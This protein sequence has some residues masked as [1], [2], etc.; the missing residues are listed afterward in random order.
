MTMV[1][2]I[3]FLFFFRALLFPFISL[4]EREIQMNRRVHKNNS[5]GSRSVSHLEL[6]KAG[7]T[8][9]IRQIKKRSNKNNTKSFQN[10]FLLFT[11]FCATQSTILDHG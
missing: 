2:I 5:E 11:F 3:N 4:Q 10:A 8:V 6:N 9:S 1:Y 7:N